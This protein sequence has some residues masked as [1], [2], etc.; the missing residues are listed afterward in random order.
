MTTTDASSVRIIPF[1]SYYSFYL[2]GLISNDPTNEFNFNFNFNCQ[3]MSSSVIRMQ[4]TIQPIVSMNT[5]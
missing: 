5:F 1:V 2:N 3:T 4:V